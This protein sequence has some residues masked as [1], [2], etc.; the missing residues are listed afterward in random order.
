[1][2]EAFT[3]EIQLMQARGQNIQ[4]QKLIGVAINKWIDNIKE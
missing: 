4:I 3:F 1:M 2:Y